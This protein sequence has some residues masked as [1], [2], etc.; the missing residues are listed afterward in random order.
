MPSDRSLATPSGRIRTRRPLVGILV[1]LLAALVGGGIA[2][3]AI[4]SNGVITGCYLKSGGTLRVIDA[5]TIKCKS[6]ETQLQ[7]NQTGPI[8]PPGTN[9]TNGTDGTDGTNGTNGTAGTNGTN[10]VSGYQLVTEDHPFG[11]GVSFSFGSVD[12][13][14]P[15]GKVALGGGGEFIN[16]Q[17]QVI[18][19]SQSSIDAS[20][21][22]ADGTGWTVSYT[23]NVDLSF[24]VAVVRAYV[25]CATAN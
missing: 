23:A 3:A 18:H 17:G 21:P 14:C 5:A 1:V 10:G 6:T 4:P 15:N 20:S 16:A 11:T 7:W 19:T 13:S 24:G 8:G 22:T 9:G 12:V 2:Y 25:T